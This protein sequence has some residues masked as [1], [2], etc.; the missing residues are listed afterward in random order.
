M[1]QMV[2]YARCVTV[3]DKQLDEKK[4]IRGANVEEQK[5]LDMMYELGRLKEVK[6]V[7]DRDNRRKD[8]QRDGHSL[9]VDQM[10]E[11]QLKR[12]KVKENL[13]R[14]A[15]E[16]LKH[17]KELEIDDK[18]QILNRKHQQKVLL[19]DICEAN[20]KAVEKKHQ[21]HAKIKEEDDKVMQYLVEKA[22]KEA[23]LAEEQKRLKDEKEREVTR[24]RELQEK[25][26]DRQSEI[27]GLRAKR[28]MENAERKA[29]EK[30]KQVAEK[31]QVLNKDLMEARRLQALEKE[32]RMQ[33]QARQERD[34]FQRIVEAQKI[35]RD[36]E[37]RLDKEK[38]SLRKGHANELRKQM[39]QNDEGRKQNARDKY[40]EGKKIR[41]K[42]E[43]E[44]RTLERIKQEKLGVLYNEIIPDKYTAELARKKIV[45]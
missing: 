15:Q 20:T 33:E 28:A 3:R 41:D 42:L 23:E 24:L 22:T 40:E 32:S 31:R 36:N 38:A 30:E 2:A 8:L 37:L 35:L 26:A 21:I 18:Q 7:D 43:A 10:K 29:R 14:E 1:N 27:D 45:L 12:L 5:R 19:D 9:I 25:A 17:I 11:R 39:A 13:A 16:M 44:R 6:R 34:E 4:L